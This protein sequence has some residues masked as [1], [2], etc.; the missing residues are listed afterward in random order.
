M[1][2][3][4]P[5]TS[6]Q[7][8]HTNPFDYIYSISSD[9]DKEIIDLLEYTLL[10]RVYYY[11][12][13]FK[14]S[15]TSKIAFWI[16][17]IALISFIFL[18]N[19]YLYTNSVKKNS[20]KGISSSY[21]NADRKFIEQG[22]QI[23][24]PVWSPAK[25]Q[26]S[27]L[28][29][30]IVILYLKLSYR[31]TFYD[32]NKLLSVG[33]LK[34][35]RQFEMVL[36][37]D[38]I[39]QGFSFTTTPEDCSFFSRLII[40]I[41]KDI[42]KPTILMA[43]GIPSAYGNDIDQRTDLI[44]QWGSRQVKFFVANNYDTDRF[45]VTGHPIYNDFPNKLRYD[46][47]EILVLTKAPSGVNLVTKS[48]DDRGRSIVYLMSIQSALSKLDVKTVRLRPH[49]SET[50]NW[51][52]KYI[53]NTFFLQDEDSLE[54]SLNKTT[55]VIGPISTVFIDALA[56]GVSYLIYEPE[57]EGLD[58]LGNKVS[59]PL[60]YNQTDIPIAKNPKQLEE[61]IINKIVAKP[62]VLKDFID[63]GFNASFIDEI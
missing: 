18:Q 55:L 49:P 14:K 63:T 27:H 54:N 44:T 30:K 53:D 34:L 40:K 45:R 32:F 1:F 46:F 20:K 8:L 50:Y 21:H 5:L 60:H 61:M 23:L 62:E 57:C 10:D 2:N 13:H 56:R 42:N 35:I 37:K 38:I 15:N 12:D 48:I 58:I 33:S 24:R 6:S 29:F 22:M 51:Y 17:N 19:A 41:F 3:K 47:K 31:L 16:K 11:G 25:F 39:K 43:H 59:S 4:N 52:A 9:D 28:T 36:K 7:K 26:K